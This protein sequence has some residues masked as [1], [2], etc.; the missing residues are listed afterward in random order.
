MSPKVAFF[1][2]H[3][4]GIGPIWRKSEEIGQKWILEPLFGEI[5]GNIELF[6]FGNLFNKGPDS[7]VGSTL[8]FFPLILLNP[9]LAWAKSRGV[10]SFNSAETMIF[11]SVIFSFLILF[12]HIH[13]IFNPNQ[14]KNLQEYKV[15][16]KSN[17]LN[18]VC[19]T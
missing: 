13:V 9:N 2:K 5:K 6:K 4:L 16:D 17:N 18:S 12:M 7:S 1:Q 3:Q 14:E 19:G 15:V 10:G 8:D 11:F